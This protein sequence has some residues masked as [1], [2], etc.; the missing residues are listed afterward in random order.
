MYLRDGKEID[1][2]DL[3]T[4]CTGIWKLVGK[5]AEQGRI[6]GFWLEHMS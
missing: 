3:A 1:V 4:V 2:C 6:P 5:M